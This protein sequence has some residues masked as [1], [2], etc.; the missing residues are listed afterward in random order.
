MDLCILSV[1]TLQPP[2]LILLILPL[3]GLK[4][5]SGFSAVIREAQQCWAIRWQEWLKVWVLKSEK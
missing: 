1:Q 3:V 5:S 2:G 4:P